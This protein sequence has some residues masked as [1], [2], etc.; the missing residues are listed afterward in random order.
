MFKHKQRLFRNNIFFEATIGKKNYFFRIFKKYWF[1]I[2]V[3]KS[4]KKRRNF[5]TKNENPTFDDIDMSSNMSV[6]CESNESISNNWHGK[7]GLATIRRFSIEVVRLFPAKNGHEHVHQQGH[8]I[9]SRA[10]WVCIQNERGRKQTAHERR[11]RLLVLKNG[12]KE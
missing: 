1:W 11:T 2:G 4:K 5:H 7:C 6:S 3:F 10:R 12:L 8:E 9:A